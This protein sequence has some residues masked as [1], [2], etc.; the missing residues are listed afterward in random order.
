MQSDSLVE[1]RA[2]Y[3]PETVYVR[4]KTGILSSPATDFVDRL[5]AFYRLD[6][7]AYHA[8]LGKGG[9]G[10]ELLSVNPLAHSATWISPGVCENH[11][12][13]WHI[14]NVR[15]VYREGSV[16]SF[17]IASLISWRSQ[18]YVIHLGPNPRPVDVGTVALAANGPG[19]PGPGGGC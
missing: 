16:R 12:G 9:L 3:F 2:L 8:H 19:H 1:A 11:F 13:Y 14:A 5:W 17:A 10:A 18:W 15:I 7:A 6:L 4:M